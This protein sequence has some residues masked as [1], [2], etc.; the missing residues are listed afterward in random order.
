M[1]RSGSNGT[2][3]IGLLW[4]LL[5]AGLYANAFRNQP[6]FPGDARTLIYIG[7]L[8]GGSVCAIMAL[9]MLSVWIGGKL[10]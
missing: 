6:A 2:A 4:A 3:M 9:C 7:S 5:S 10:D 8:M 1:T